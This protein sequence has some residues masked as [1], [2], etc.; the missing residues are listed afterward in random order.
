MLKRKTET[1]VE[2]FPKPDGN[3]TAEQPQTLTGDRA[4][5]WRRCGPGPSVAH[6]NCTAGLRA[7]A[8]LQAGRRHTRREPHR[9]PDL[10]GTRHGPEV[11]Q[12]L[13]QDRAVHPRRAR[14]LG[15]CEDRTG[16][17]ARLPFSEIRH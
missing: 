15:E 17:Q 14:R 3:A 11:R 7:P 1:Q 10:A 5:G 6:R 9:A 8:H 4:H 2:M 13:A 12:V 16:A